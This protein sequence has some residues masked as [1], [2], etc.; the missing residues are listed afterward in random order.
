M[1]ILC[2]RQWRSMVCIRAVIATSC[3]EQCAA[4][5]VHAEECVGPPK[6]KTVLARGALLLFKMFQTQGLGIYSSSTMH[7]HLSDFFV[8]ER[9]R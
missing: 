1:T 4:L 3:T 8:E 7:L 9:M 5:V 6:D 2:H